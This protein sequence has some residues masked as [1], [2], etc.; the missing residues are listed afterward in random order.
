MESKI[1]V[2]ICDPYKEAEIKEIDNTLETLQG[3]VGGYIEVVR[4][5]HDDD[6]ILICNEEGILRNLPC[7]RIVAT[8][9]IFGTFILCG[10]DGDEFASLDEVNLKFAHAIYKEP[11]SESDIYNYIMHKL[12]IQEAWQDETT[13]P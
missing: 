12:A 13:E 3:I 4:P 8:Q 2:L 6:M 1:K 7:R 9:P 10:R 11:W 5:W